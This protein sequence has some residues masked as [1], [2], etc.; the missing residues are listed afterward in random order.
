MKKLL[1]TINVTLLVLLLSPIIFTGNVNAQTEIPAGNVSG[2][3]SMANSPCRVNG[4]ITVPHGSTLTI[5]P[6]VKVIF[7]GSYKLDVKGCVLA[8]GTASDTITFTAEDPAVGWQAVKFLNTSASN[9]TSRFIYCKLEYGILNKGDALAREGGSFA[10]KDFS[11]LIIS[12]CLLHHNLVVNNG[13][14]LSGKGGGI[15]LWNA[16]PKITYNTIINNQATGPDADGGG[17]VCYMNS[18]PIISNNLISNNTVQ[19]TGGGVFIVSSSPFLSNNIITDNHAARGGGLIIKYNSSPVIIN[20]T[21]AFNSGGSGGGITYWLNADPLIINTILYGNMADTGSQVSIIDSDCDPVFV[22]CDIEGGKESFGGDGAGS[23]YNGLYRYNLETDPLFSD[24]ENDDFKLKDGSPCI[25]AGSATTVFNKTLY[26]AP[27]TDFADN[28]RPGPAL[29]IPDIGALENE[30][31]VSD[32]TR[33]ADKFLRKVYHFDQDSIQYRLFVPNYSGN[34]ERFPLVLTLHGDGSK[35]LDNNDHIIRARNAE[36]WAEDSVQLKYPAFIL[37]PQAPLLDFAPMVTYCINTF[38]PKTIELLND[39]IAEYPIDTTRLYI[40]GFEFGAILTLSNIYW[41]Q[42]GKFAA[43][44]PM[45]G[46]WLLDWPPQITQI[47]VWVFHGELD[48]HFPV[49]DSRNLMKK[50]SDAN[51]EVYTVHSDPYNIGLTGSGLD[52]LM[53]I[54]VNHIYT[55]FTGIGHDSNIWNTMYDDPILHRWLFAQKKDYNFMGIE[56]KTVATAA[57]CGL[58]DNYPNP[59]HTETNIQFQIP[60]SCRVV[61]KIY[62]ML[63]EEIR[64]LASGLYPA[65]QHVVCWDGKNNHGE[66]TTAGTYICQMRA[67]DFYQVKKILLLHK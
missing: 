39:L 23:N 32:T 9:D 15:A 25:S 27:A 4:D 40:T 22:N 2:T 64:I 67:G 34:S 56:S 48:A 29:S 50:L 10:V 1:R 11:K 24:P 63:G 18:N 13:D 41:L 30:T 17:I 3:W 12:H 38:G 54:G 46:R 55:E 65:G 8:V 57:F 20:N 7:T 19:S 62:S 51:I 37:A 36:A 42:P 61:L 21:I 5:E 14:E 58:L 33:P 45:S 16:S 31:G 47:P 35:G 59:F 43:A 66:N 44:I 28:P 6:G 49:S 53:N 60:E 26:S 52:S